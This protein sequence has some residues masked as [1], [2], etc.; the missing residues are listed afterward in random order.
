METWEFL[1]KYKKEIRV[2]D[3]D[4]SINYPKECEWKKIS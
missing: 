2:D 1:R 3:I 4:G